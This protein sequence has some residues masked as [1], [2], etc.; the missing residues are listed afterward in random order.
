MYIFSALFFPYSHLRFYP[1][2]ATVNFVC[3]LIAAET[4]E[5]L[6]L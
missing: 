6:A 2:V 3:C 4:Q 1:F 5:V